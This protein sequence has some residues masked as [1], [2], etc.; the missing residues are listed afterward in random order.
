MVSRGVCS[1]FVLTQGPRLRGLHLRTS[2]TVM[3]SKEE[4]GE[5]TPAAGFPPGDSHGPKQVI[6]SL[7]ASQGEGGAVLSRGGK[8]EIFSHQP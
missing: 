3:T 6:G 7:P 4:R 5:D 2:V 8:T 1:V